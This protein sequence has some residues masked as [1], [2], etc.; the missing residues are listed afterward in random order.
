MA[1]S[2]FLEIQVEIF[3]IDFEGIFY[4]LSSCYIHL[5]LFF[6][7]HKQFTEMKFYLSFFTIRTL[8]NF[9]R[10]LYFFTTKSYEDKIGWLIV[11]DI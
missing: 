4:A 3:M 6:H 7:F 1:I 2:F 10:N 9:K 8:T 11:S 5:L